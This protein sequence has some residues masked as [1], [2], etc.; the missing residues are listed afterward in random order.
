MNEWQPYNSV[1]AIIN[2]T[3]YM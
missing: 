3:R 1:V 2:I